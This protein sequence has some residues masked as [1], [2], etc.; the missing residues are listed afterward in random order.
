MKDDRLRIPA[1]APYLAA[2]GRATYCFAI[3]EWNAVYCGEKLRPGY[4]GTVGRKTAGTIAKEV[5]GCAALVT[6]PGTYVRYVAATAEF[7]RLVRCRNDLMHANPATVGG[8]QRLIRHGI[9]W[10]PDEIDDLA[11]QFAACSIELNELHRHVI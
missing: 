3:L 1:D 11:D 5:A 4:G 10:Q 2:I 6:D 9:P 8:D 7:S